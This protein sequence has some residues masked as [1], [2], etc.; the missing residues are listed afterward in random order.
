MATVSDGS[1]DNGPV[2]DEE[3]ADAP[4]AG[5][6]RR[7]A[8]KRAAVAVRDA[9]GDGDAGAAEG[10][11]ASRNSA[12]SHHSSAGELRL[13]PWY[14]STSVGDD[15]SDDSG[16]SDEE[17]DGSALVGEEVVPN[18]RKRPLSGGNDSHTRLRMLASKKPASGRDTTAVPSRASKEDAPMVG[19]VHAI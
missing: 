9:V 3:F 13:W 6:R 4:A 14:T 12:G 1:G 19:Y 7:G 17:E 8:D 16:S 10:D 11:A 5:L 15:G 18:S 2:L